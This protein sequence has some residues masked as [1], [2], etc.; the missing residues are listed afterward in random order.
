MAPATASC[1]GIIVSAHR[2]RRFVLSFLNG[3]LLE[4][5]GGLVVDD[6]EGPLAALNEFPPDWNADLAEEMRDLDISRDAI[7]GIK[8]RQSS[9]LVLVW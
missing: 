6:A 5:E 1:N 4:E 7:H 2:L 9:Q 3:F 8:I